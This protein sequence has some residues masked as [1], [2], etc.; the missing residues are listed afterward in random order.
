M[1]IRSFP[2]LT[3]S[4]NTF[5]SR[6]QNLNTSNILKIQIICPQC[7][8]Y[9]IYSFH[10]CIYTAS[11]LLCSLQHL[12]FLQSPE[13][14]HDSYA[15]HIQ[16]CSMNSTAVNSIPIKLVINLSIVSTVVRA[17]KCKM[18]I[19]FQHKDVFLTQ[20]GDTTG[21]DSLFMK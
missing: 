6:M 11:L 15:Q 16:T 3:R 13:R 17:I 12:H 18:R 2:Q 10:K 4:E 7:R 5:Q 1:L 14:N 20:L 21:E 9:T 8:N 19:H